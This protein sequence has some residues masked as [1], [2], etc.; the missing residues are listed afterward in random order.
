MTIDQIHA[1]VAAH[2]PVSRRQVIRY[3]LDDLKISPSGARQRP[4]QYPD[5]ADKLILAHLGVGHYPVVTV[6]EYARLGAKALL[7]T[8]Q[9]AQSTGTAWKKRRP[10]STL[11]TMSQ[12]RAERQKARG[13]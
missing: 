8:K 13:K 11:P 4:Q 7:D 1:A 3:M 9:R 6:A 5:G 2:K 12:L 10:A